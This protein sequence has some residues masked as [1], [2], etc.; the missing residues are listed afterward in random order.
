MRRSLATF[1]FILLGFIG[2]QGSL[3]KLSAQTEDVVGE[4]SAPQSFHT[5]IPELAV[6]VNSPE[7]I[8]WTL[9]ANFVFRAKLLST[10]ERSGTSENIP[11]SG[12]SEKKENLHLREL[13]LQVSDVYILPPGL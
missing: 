9:E 12:A 10:S 5:R 6:K 4:V 3:L 13:K 8:D 11:T 7:I 2:S 1:L